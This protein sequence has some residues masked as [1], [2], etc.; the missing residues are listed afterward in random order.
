[1]LFCFSYKINILDI[2]YYQKYQRELIYFFSIEF[3]IKNEK[4]INKIIKIKK[5]C[6][7]N[8]I[9]NFKSFFNEKKFFNI[10]NNNNLI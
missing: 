3:N 10:N 7:F 5:L 8:A 2:L 1:M 9:K 4:L 6:I